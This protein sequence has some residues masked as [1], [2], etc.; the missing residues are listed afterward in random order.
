MPNTH[1]YPD[2]DLQEALTR[3][4]IARQLVTA[5][6]RSTLSLADLWQHVFAALDDTFT[7][8][9]EVARLRADLA[10]ARHSRANLI[11]AA[12]ATL[13]AHHEGESDH[14]WYLRDELDGGDAR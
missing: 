1:P 5:F 7:L 10:R 11:A 2:R 12:R 3:N 14:L 9:A 4:Q 13:S 8:I 6:S